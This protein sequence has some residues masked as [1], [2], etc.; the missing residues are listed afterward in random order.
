MVATRPRRWSW[1]WGG[2]AALKDNPNFKPVGP[3]DD[4]RIRDGM[5]YL[6]AY[7]A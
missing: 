7:F 1:P 2:S 6:D 4:W 3:D 5:E